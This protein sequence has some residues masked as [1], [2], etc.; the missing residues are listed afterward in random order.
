[1]MRPVGLVLFSDKVER[2]FFPQSGEYAL[3]AL[4]Q[5]LEDE[6][7]LQGKATSFGSIEAYIKRSQDLMIFLVSD[8]KD[9]SIQDSWL[10]N[11]KTLGID[12][13]PII[14][15]D[16]VERLG[17]STSGY[18]H[19]R[20]PETGALARAFVSRDEYSKMLKSA[21][22]YY[23][24]VRGMFNESAELDSCEINDCYRRLKTHFARKSA[25]L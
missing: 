14:I 7:K 18:F 6:P 22:E 9:E 17:I 11:T 4:R 21:E 16:P 8:F 13:T 15:R 24:R 19:C 25:N 5:F 23:A 20:N 10:A 3:Y 1:M 2:V 12:F